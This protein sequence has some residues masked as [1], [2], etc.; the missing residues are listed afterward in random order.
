MK[1]TIKIKESEEGFA[2]WCD[3]LPGCASQGSTEE[4]AIKNMEDAIEEYI[5]LKDE[6]AKSEKLIEIEVN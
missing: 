6:L 1:Y 3:Q 2:V 5:K 4:E